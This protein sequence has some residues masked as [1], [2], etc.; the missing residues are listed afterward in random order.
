M[1]RAPG[2]SG[3]RCVELASSVRKDGCPTCSLV[4]IIR[5]IKPRPSG[6]AG[7]ATGGGAGT[8]G[9]CGGAGG[10]GGRGGVGGTAAATGGGAG[11]TGGGGSAGGHWADGG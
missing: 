9:G 5:S 10:T 6:W 8:T 1:V 2:L 7:A 3:N 11:G 4:V